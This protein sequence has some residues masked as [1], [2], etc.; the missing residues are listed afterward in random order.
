MSK[1]IGRSTIF[2]RLKWY[3][4]GTNRPGPK[5]L[6]ISAAQTLL[7]NSARFLTFSSRG[8]GSK[9]MDKEPGQ[10]S[11]DGQ[12]WFVL[13]HPQLNTISRELKYQLSRNDVVFNS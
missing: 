12:V 2:S 7:T 4:I 8:I 10:F 1:R 5:R 11:L 9:R 13:I 3:T 6:S